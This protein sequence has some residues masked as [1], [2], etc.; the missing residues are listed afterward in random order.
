MKELNIENFT[1]LSYADKKSLAKSI[2]EK[3]GNDWEVTE[4]P[5]NVD[6]IFLLYKPYKIKFALIPGGKFTMGIT[7]SDIKDAK[8]YIE[9]N[10]DVEEIVENKKQHA[11]PVHTVTVDPFLC[12]VEP[13]EGENL[14][15]ILKR[16]LEEGGFELREVRNAINDLN[17]RLPS[18]AEFEWLARE[19]GIRSSILNIGPN[20]ETLGSKAEQQPHRFGIECMYYSQWV[21]DDW[22]EDYTD[23]PTT[24][25]PW[26]NGDSVGVLRGGMYLEMI[27]SDEGLISSFAGMRRSGVIEHDGFIMMRFAKSLTL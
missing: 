20:Y 14:E 2:C 13:M 19:G 5:K 8:T 6:C 24:S 1:K 4:T 7:D 16:E 27:E 21:E 3:L 12:A 11:L 17:F 25:A 22:H 15:A 9:W 18:E 10:D 23:A 26:M